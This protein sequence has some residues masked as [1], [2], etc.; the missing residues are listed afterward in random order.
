MKKTLEQEL[1]NLIMR[2]FGKSEKLRPNDIRLDDGTKVQGL[3]YPYLFLLSELLDCGSLTMT[4]IARRLEITTAAATGAVDRL[5]A[6]GLATR[7]HDL[8][9]DRRKIWAVITKRGVSTVEKFKES[10]ADVIKGM[11]EGGAESL[12]SP[13]SEPALSRLFGVVRESQAVA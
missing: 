13:Q 9:E 12:T 1:A 8:D 2:V 7:S 4:D 3:S 11:L 5:E 6:L 10:L